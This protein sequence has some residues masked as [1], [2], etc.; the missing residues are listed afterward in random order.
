M[1][2]RIVFSKKAFSDIDR[3]IE[4]NNRRN[5]SDTYSRKFLTKLHKR[6]NL[7]QKYPLTGV[8][9]DEENVLLLVWDQYYVFYSCDDVNIEI[10]SIYHQKEDVIR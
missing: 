3:I 4:F 1:A 7:L 2:K 9:T 10:K 8:A 5:Q 6:L